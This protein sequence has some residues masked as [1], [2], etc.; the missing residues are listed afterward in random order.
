MRTTRTLVEAVERQLVRHREIFES[1]RSP[2]DIFINPPELTARG[3]TANVP[4]MHQLVRKFDPAVTS[5]TGHSAKR[6]RSSCSATSATVP[7][8]GSTGTIF[9]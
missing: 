5:A 3:A 9:R 2:Q 1:P 4:A 7:S 8:Y 6:A